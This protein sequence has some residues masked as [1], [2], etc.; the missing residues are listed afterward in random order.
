MSRL[1][2]LIRL[3]RTRQGLTHKQVA[4]KCGVSDKYLMEVE[5]GTRIIQDDQARRILKS[6][7]LQQQTEADFTLEDIAATVDLQSAVPQLTKAVE[8]KKPVKEKENVVAESDPGVSGSIWLDAL[9]GVLKHVP[10]YNAVMKEVGHRLLP[11]TNGKIEGAS[12]D[13]VFYFMAPDNELRGFRVQRGDLLL[14]VPAQ[15]AVDGAIMLIQTPQGRLL[16]K[17][18]RVNDYQAMLQKYN[19]SC[20]SEIK[21]YNEITFVGRCVRLEADLG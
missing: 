7:G 14:V 12:P 11:I 13:K 19:E 6:M 1:G 15:A 5:A 2:D 4:R 18:K 3:E 10:I 16:R 17:V 9:S 8:T 21:N 20:E